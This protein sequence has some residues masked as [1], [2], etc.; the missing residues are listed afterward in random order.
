MDRS[1]TA[2]L[3]IGMLLLSSAHA[4]PNERKL[5]ESTDDDGGSAGIIIFILILLFSVYTL[6]LGIIVVKEK[7][8]V[9]IERLGKFHKLLTP[10]FHCIIPY[11]DRYIILYNNM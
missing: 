2:T 10:G 9:V 1:T 5:A 7:E 4:L 3:L 11:I 6:Y 8:T